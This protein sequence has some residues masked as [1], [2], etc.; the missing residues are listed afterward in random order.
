[1][2]SKGNMVRKNLKYKLYNWWWNA[3]NQVQEIKGFEVDYFDK[4]EYFF[5]NFCKL[6]C[7][8]VVILN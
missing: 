1:M 7:Q 5:I 3:W 6:I 2:I 4:I 8:P